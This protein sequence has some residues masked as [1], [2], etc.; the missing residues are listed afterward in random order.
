MIDSKNGTT[1]SQAMALLTSHATAEWYTPPEYI[2]MALAVMG[3]INLDPASNLVAQKWVRAGMWYDQDMDGLSRKWHGTVW[4][5]PPYGKNA[6]GK[7]LQEIWSRKLVAEY[8]AGR[9]TQAVLL[10]NSTHGY[11]WYEDLADRWTVCLARE[12]IRFIK[13]DG[14]QG[15]PA[16]RGQSFFYLGPNVN[17][18]REVFSTIGRVHP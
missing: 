8:E 5:N 9:T 15:G 18:F 3:S 16:K 7:S 6:A 11:K 14:T 10:V 17:R 4:L 13:P 1:M 2:V 12:R